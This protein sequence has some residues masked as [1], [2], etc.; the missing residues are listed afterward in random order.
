MFGMSDSRLSDF[1]APPT[2]IAAGALFATLE[3]VWAAFVGGVLFTSGWALQAVVV[4][5]KYG[6]GGEQR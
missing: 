2:L 3:L 4:R 5:E 1:F 6:I